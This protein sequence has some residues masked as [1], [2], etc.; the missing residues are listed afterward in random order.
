LGDRARVSFDAFTDLE[1]PARV[2]SIGALAKPAGRRTAWVSQVLLSLTLDCTD[3]RLIPNLTVRADVI[4]GS[5]QSHGIIPREA[6]F[7]YREAGHPFAWVETGS[8]W[9]KRAV[10]PGLANHVDV[11]IRSGLNPGERVALSDPSA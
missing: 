9:Q 3:P 11:S 7:H 4:V 10:E 6:V 8:G 5:E 2:R 1:L